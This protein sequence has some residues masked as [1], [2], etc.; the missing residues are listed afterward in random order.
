MCQVPCGDL[1][2]QTTVP[3]FKALSILLI[4]AVDCGLGLDL[5]HTNLIFLGTVDAQ[6]VFFP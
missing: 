6:G 4:M 2:I 1:Q 5:L 3:A